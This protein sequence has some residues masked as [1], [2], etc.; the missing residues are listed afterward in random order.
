[1]IA[2]LHQYQR[3]KKT[4]THQGQTIQ[5]IE[6]TLA[7]IDLANKLASEVL[8]HSLDEMAPATR[9]LLNLIWQMV[10]GRMKQDNL[11]QEACLFSRRELRETSG[12]SD[13][14]LR[15]H[16]GQLVELEYLAV[17]S[18]KNGQKYLYELLYQGEGQAGDKFMLGLLDVKQLK[19]KVRQHL[20]GL[21]PNL[22]GKPEDPAASKHTTCGQLADQ[23]NSLETQEQQGLAQPDI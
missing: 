11:K 21:K 14:Q 5:Y 18:G 17:R 3:P 9:R 22:A 16:L 12:W 2:F 23:E 6:A 20:A 15:V 8:G 19:Q 1:M 4:A 13:T 7:D 10:E